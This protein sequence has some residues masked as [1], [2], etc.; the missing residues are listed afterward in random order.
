MVLVAVGIWFGAQHNTPGQT[1]GVFG[2]IAILEI[3]LVFVG[4]SFGFVSFGVMVTFV[5]VAL[6]ILAVFF[7]QIM[8][9]G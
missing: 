7:R 6:A 1:T 9:G 8:A 3:L 4:V 2:F 5:V